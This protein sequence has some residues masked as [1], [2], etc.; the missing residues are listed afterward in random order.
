MEQRAARASAQVK[1]SIQTK[2]SWIP[3][4][5]SSLFLVLLVAFRLSEQEVEV[6]SVQDLNL[7]F[8]GATCGTG[9]VSLGHLPRHGNGAQRQ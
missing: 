5:M 7:D 4:E 3:T 6:R 2:E 1:I 9:Q 8:C